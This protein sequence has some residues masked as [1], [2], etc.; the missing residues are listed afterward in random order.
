MSSIPLSFKAQD[1]SQAKTIAYDWLSSR[2][3][4]KFAIVQ[5]EEILQAIL[6]IDAAI[7]AG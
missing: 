6:T 4:P 1:Y 5:T 2:K 3:L 7:V